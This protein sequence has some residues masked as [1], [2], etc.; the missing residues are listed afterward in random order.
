MQQR[1][2]RPRARSYLLLAFLSALAVLHAGAAHAQLRG[3]VKTDGGL[4]SAAPGTST[5]SVFKGI[6]YAAPPQGELRWKPPQAPAAWSGVRAGDRFGPKCMQTGPYPVLDDDQPQSEDCLYLNVWSPA[7]SGQDGLPVMVWIHGGQF[8]AGSGARYASWE[9]GASLAGKGVVL[10]TINY[11]LGL[12]GF[13]S[14]PELTAESPHRASGNYGILDAIAALQ[15]VQRNIRAFGGN[16]GNVTVFG[17]SAGAEIVSILLAAPEAKGLFHRGISESGGSFAWRQPKR[18][19]E[20]EA[21]GVGFMKKLG[22]HNLAELRAQPAKRLVDSRP[23]RFEPVIDGWSY[24]TPLYE[25]LSAGRGVDVPLI[26]GSNADEGQYSPTGTAA[27]WRAEVT[28]Q[29]G[30]HADAILARYPATDD[31]TARHSKRLSQTLQADFIS[32]TLASLS[33]R[34]GTAPVFLYRFEHVPPASKIGRSGAY[35]GAEVPYV[36]ASLNQQERVWTDVDRRLERVLSS[37][38]V[39]FA[40]TGDPNGPGLPQWRSVQADGGAIL[41][42]SDDARMTKREHQQGVELLQEAYYGPRGTLRSE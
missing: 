39:N 6:P 34:A 5:V 3:P 11:R 32:W 19:A 41:K 21:M 40:R 30:Q 17:Q 18:L 24:P 22:S 42:I 13:M 31:E 38:W 28:Q 33:A 25:V 15:W 12:L 35:H 14:H 26:V 29:F 4:I 20:A 2:K 37:Y 1:S 7:R 10:V 27:E 8:L 23:P 9:D 36:F 16:P